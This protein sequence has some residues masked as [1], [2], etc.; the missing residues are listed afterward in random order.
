MSNLVNVLFVSLI[1][2]KTALVSHLSSVL[3]AETFCLWSFITGF[4]AY[5]IVHW[6]HVRTFKCVFSLIFCFERVTGMFTKQALFRFA[7]GKL[8]VFSLKSR[9]TQAE[10]CIYAK[11][12]CHILWRKLLYSNLS[13]S[14]YNWTHFYV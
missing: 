9:L 2:C 4:L 3:F 11:R 13:E 7:S 6:D 10:K 14:F 12:S 5:F 1:S 8:R